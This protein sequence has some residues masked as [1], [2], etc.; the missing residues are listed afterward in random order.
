[1]KSFFLLLLIS[2][3]FF[4]VAQSGLGQGKVINRKKNTV[5]TPSKLKAREFKLYGYTDSTQILYS[6][7]IGC[8]MVCLDIDETKL[9]QILK[10]GIVNV[11]LSNLRS[12][13]KKYT[14]DHFFGSSLHR[15]RVVPMNTSLKVMSLEKHR[16]NSQCDC[17]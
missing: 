10:E 6:N 13:P 15:V 17:D 4:S 16:N 7:T 2:Q 8:K 12:N 5:A 14:V 11:E 1:M 9:R 3:P